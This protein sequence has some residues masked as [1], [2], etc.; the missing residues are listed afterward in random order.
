M[1]KTT[2]IGINGGIACGKDTVAT[3]IQY[4]TT[5]DKSEKLLDRIKSGLDVNGYHNSEW[6][7]RKFADKLKDM[8][9]L[10]I[11]CTRQELESQE[12]KNKPLSEEWC[13]WYLTHYKLNN[14]RI[15]D[16]YSSEEEVKSFIN[17]DEFKKTNINDY[18]V[19]SKIL[20]PR[21]ILQLLGTEGGRKVIHP[22]IWVNSLFADYKARDKGKAHDMKD[23]SELYRHKECKSCKKSY[24]GYKRQYLCKECIEDESIQFYPKWLLTDMR[25]PNEMKA[26][27]QRNGLT[28]KVTRP[29]YLRFPELFKVYS[30]QET[31]LSEK[32]FIDWLSTYDNEKYEILTHPSET[33]LVDESFDYTI[34]NDTNIDDLIEKVSE[35][36]KR[37][38]IL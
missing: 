2:L 24:S 38:N 22:Q 30:D 25:F 37:E 23:F 26:V 29:Y 16:L 31:E 18:Q 13:I 5:A 12:F 34:V 14:R 17:S 15:S 21:I 3:I 19:E 9:C 32:N 10:L 8:V 33:S 4:L 35:I 6:I 11:G 28:I 27:E 7:V 36:L 1:K 20:T